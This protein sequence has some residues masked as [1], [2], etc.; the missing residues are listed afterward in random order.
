MILKTRPENGSVSSG[1][2]SAGSPEGVCPCTGGTSVGAG[3]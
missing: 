2:R 3:R 1:V